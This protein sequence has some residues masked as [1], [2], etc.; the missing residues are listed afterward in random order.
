M[1]YPQLVSANF[2]TQP[3]PIPNR[4]Q[5]KN[6]ACGDAWEVDAW[7]TRERFLILGSESEADYVTQRAST[8][9]KAHASTGLLSQ[10]DFRLADQTVGSLIRDIAPHNDHTV[11]AMALCP[12]CGSD[13]IRVV[14]NQFV[15][16]ATKEGP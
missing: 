1:K 10:V 11:F 5:V 4:A 14:N 6:S 2:N 12:S 9:D 15:L 3:Y 7:T 13:M 8:F 16:S